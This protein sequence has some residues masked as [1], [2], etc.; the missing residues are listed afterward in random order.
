M[1]R[2]RITWLLFAAALALVVAGASTAQPPPGKKGPPGK[3]GKQLTTED[4]VNHI[5]SFDKSKL[6]KVSKEDLPERLQYLVE[7]GDVNK[8]GYLD[9]DEIG[10]LADK[11]ALKGPGGKGGFGGPPGGPPGGKANFGPKGGVSVLPGFIRDQLDLTEEQEQKIREMDKETRSK[12]MKILT[13]DQQKKMDALFKK[14]P[15]GKGP[16]GKDGPPPPP[17]PASG[18]NGSAFAPG[19]ALVLNARQEP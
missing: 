15:P 6:G 19:S 13:P 11:L 1:Q 4:V 2:R 14:G 8:D 5:L 18:L 7:L 3:F 16:G 17:P 10:A 9:R 12:L